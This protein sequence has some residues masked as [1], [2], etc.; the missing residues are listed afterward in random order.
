MM[1]VCEIERRQ[2]RLA[3]VPSIGWPEL[4]DSRERL[5]GD[6]RPAEAG[7]HVWHDDGVCSWSGFWS[8]THRTGVDGLRRGREA[9]VES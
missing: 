1:H 9:R 3:W 7:D 2:M 8:R 6:D 4:A 5:M